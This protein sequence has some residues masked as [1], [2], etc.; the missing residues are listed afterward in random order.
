MVS[1]TGRDGDSDSEF[2]LA[3]ESWK[4]LL[5]ATDQVVDEL[6]DD[7]D[8]LI[9]GGSISDSNLVEWMPRRFLPRY[10]L[11]F[12]Q[13]LVERVGDLAVRL[14]RGHQE[15]W[16][17]PH[18][19]FLKSVVEEMLMAQIIRYAI[20]DAASDESREELQALEDLSFEDRDFEWLYD[21]SHDG[22]TDDPEV[23]RTFGFANLRFEDWFKPFR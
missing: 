20:D 14:D 10:D 11:A 15:G 9:Q 13:G 16:P 5:S 18:E 8:E 1:G 7:V 17:Y 23:A 12:A 19:T 3:E 2:R 6:R 4:A 22:I 21:L